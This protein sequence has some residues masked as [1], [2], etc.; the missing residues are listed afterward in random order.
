MTRCGI[1]QRQEW[2]AESWD[3]PQKVSFAQIPKKQTKYFGSLDDYVWDC[4]GELKTRGF[5]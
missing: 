5:H 2:L 4:Y 1:S 3:M